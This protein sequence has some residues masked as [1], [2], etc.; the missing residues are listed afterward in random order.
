MT[1]SNQLADLWPA[2]GLRVS[3]GDLE[4]RWI[5]DEL[6]VQLAH[7]ASEG[8]NEPDRMPFSV[9][10]TRG[11]R[12]EVARN[13]LSYQWA[14][15]SHLGP[16]RL[17]LE[18]AV[19]VDGK[20]V[21]IQA[22]SGENWS[23]LRSAET[24]SWLGRGYQGQSIGSRMRAMMLHLLFDGLGAQQVTSTA[25]ADNPASNRVSLKT[26]YEPNG[27]LSAERDGQAVPMNRYLMTAARFET[28]RARLLE[29]LGD[30][31]R[32]EGADAVRA[33]LEGTN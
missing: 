26:G 27:T 25:F 23:V 28:Q 2:S 15:R 10:W 21:G 5:D 7:V 13:V 3:S 29:L 32:I 1:L 20:P 22:A 17:V 30:C 12:E 24:G 6:L 4:L 18:L 8:I 14:A 11:A 16:G 19:L 9:P 33:Q 31:V